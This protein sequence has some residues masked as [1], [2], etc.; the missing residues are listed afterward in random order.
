[1]IRR[2]VEEVLA[3][4]DNRT[5]DLGGRLSTRAMGDLIVARSGSA[6]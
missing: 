6:A 3:N 4:P 5:P 1:M 2:A